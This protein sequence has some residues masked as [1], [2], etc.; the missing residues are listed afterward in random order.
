MEKAQLH[1]WIV[2]QVKVL[3]C[4]LA[5]FG[6]S[7]IAVL[8]L[9]QDNTVFAAVAAGFALL[10]IL[11]AAY[12]LWRRQRRPSPYPE[13]ALVGLLCVFTLFGMQ[14]DTQV[15]H[16]IY[17]MPLF[18]YFLFPLHLANI[19]ILLYT[20]VLIMTV[21]NEF[22]GYIRQQLLFSY[23]ACYAFS[24]IYALVN[25]R[26]NRAMM[27]IINT[28]PLTQVYN[29]GQFYLD[30]AKEMTRA[31]RQ[32]SSLWLLAVSVPAAWEQ[33]SVDEYEY[34]LAFISSQLTACLR[35]YDTCYRFDDDQFV[36][37]LPQCSVDEVALRQ[38]QL[39]VTLANQ[40][41]F[42]NDC[43]RVRVERY[44]ADDDAQRLV[45]RLLENAYV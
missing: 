15:V 33:L 38:Q 4:L 26:N 25:E 10:L 29:E 45:R 1:S 11:Y 21:L 34:R 42:A 2:M 23:A 7:V 32:Q 37:I 41:S 18:T 30:V 20:V 35:A 3:Y 8:D 39:E 16:W 36:A 9:W 14:Q 43:I 27:K 31:D 5:A 28:D 40:K 22:D 24:V 12:L 13:W 19:I 44:R 6:L 17:F